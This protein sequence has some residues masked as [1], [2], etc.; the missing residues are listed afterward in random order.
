MR[1]RPVDLDTDRDELLAVLDRNLTDLPHARRFQWLYRDHPLGRALAWFVCDGPRQVVGIASL[2]PRA[3][4]LG[5][6]VVSGGQVGD[7][8]I[9]AAHRSLG[10]AVMLQRA[11]F[12]PVDS[13]V[14]HCCY[15]CPPHERGMST[16]RRLG[17]KP[18]AV[19]VRYACLLRTDRQLTR[20]L[21]RS[22]AAGISP[23]ANAALRLSRIRHRPS[24]GL[25]IAIHHGRFGAE[26][27][28]LDGRVG[29]A[30]GIRGRRTAEDLN[31]R[32]RDD[33]LADYE[34]LTARRRGELEGFAVLAVAG[35][36][37]SLVDVFGVLPLGDTV[38]LLDA[39]VAHAREM[40]GET[41]HACV[42]E[43]SRLADALVGAGLRSRA[44]GPLVVVYS[45]GVVAP[46]AEG[47]ALTYSDIMA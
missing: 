31:W 36:D 14:L 9:D 38:A 10:P 22:V 12:E 23:L 5:G 6:R 37:P 41:L 40:G 7:F 26:F 32:F 20:R 29:G 27:S 30:A 39:A 44:R 25:D 18:T 43:G 21:S 24:P 2:F 33:P 16:F 4:W 42:S 17:I 19:M 34:V 11:T 47:W 13:G 46:S 1:V 28:A 8:A 35:A 45:G 15:D 3:M